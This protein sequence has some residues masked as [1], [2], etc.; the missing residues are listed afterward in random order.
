MALAASATP[1]FLMRRLTFS[2][3]VVPAACCG[4]AGG[5]TLQALAGIIR[6]GWR[7]NPAC[8]H[9]TQSLVLVPRRSLDVLYCRREP[10]PPP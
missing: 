9:Y 8:S 1:V 3:R 10:G 7:N 2:G 5:Y 6:V 4:T